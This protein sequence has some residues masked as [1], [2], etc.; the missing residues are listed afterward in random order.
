MTDDKAP[1][2]NLR[3]PGGLMTG[4]EDPARRGRPAKDPLGREIS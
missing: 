3:G 1:A 2:K 4:T